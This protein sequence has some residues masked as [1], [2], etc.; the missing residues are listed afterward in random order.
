MSE[1][2][3]KIILRLRT[4]NDM[5]QKELADRVGITE[6][7]LSR[8]ENDLRS[9]KGEIVFKLA[10]ALG[11]SSDYLLSGIDKKETTSSNIALNEAWGKNVKLTDKDKKDI[12]KNLEN[13]MDNLDKVEGLEFYNQPQDE[14]DIEFIKRGF[15]RFLEDVKLYNKLKYTPKRYRKDK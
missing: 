2:I 5:K 8:Y 9:P 10:E 3:G 1:T 12:A 15:E 7:T 6:A 11:V 14:D 4:E 13:M